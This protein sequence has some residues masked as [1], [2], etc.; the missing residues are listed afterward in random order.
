MMTLPLT[1]GTP[2][3]GNG[4]G[5]QRENG[6]MAATLKPLLAYTAEVTTDGRSVKFSKP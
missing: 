4:T 3:E 2:I 1:V 5:A 6:K